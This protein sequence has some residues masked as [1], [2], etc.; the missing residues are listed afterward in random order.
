MMITIDD[1][2][3][4]IPNFSRNDFDCPCCGMNNI[5]DKFIWKLQFARTEARIPFI[6][7]SGCRCEKYN[8]KVRGKKSSDHLTGEGVDIRCLSSS[9]RWKIVTSAISAGFRRIGIAKT[10]IH[11]GDNWDNPQ[12]VMWMY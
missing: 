10:Y 12:N 6:I 2:T 7:N 1:N 3:I 11:L 8:R 5:K 4:Q 9:D